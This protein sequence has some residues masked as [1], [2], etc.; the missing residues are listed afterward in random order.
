MKRSA[1]PLVCGRYARVNFWL[2]PSSRQVAANRAEWK[3]LPLSVNTRWMG[4]PKRSK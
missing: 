4:T 3:H 1:L 2:M